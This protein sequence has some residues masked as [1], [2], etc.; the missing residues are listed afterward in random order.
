MSAPDGLP[1][2]QRHCHGF[3]LYPSLIELPSTVRHSAGVISRLQSN[4]VLAGAGVVKAV[5][6]LADTKRSAS[7]T[8]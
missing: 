5:A 2:D 1:W 8:D 4:G 3:S 7:A 6:A